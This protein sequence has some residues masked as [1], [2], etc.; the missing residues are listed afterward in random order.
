[1]DAV[2][3]SDNSGTRQLDSKVSYFPSH[4]RAAEQPD[5]QMLWE[6]VK[7]YRGFDY[8]DEAEFVAKQIAAGLG[9]PF[10]PHIRVGG[11]V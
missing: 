4:V 2:G 3:V 8:R 7:S 5:G 11:L 10:E 9:V 1:M 6:V